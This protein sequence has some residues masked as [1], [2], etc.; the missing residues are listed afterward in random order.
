M[1]QPSGG[2]WLPVT[3]TTDTVLMMP[4]R[5]VST[6]PG[7]IQAIPPQV[8]A[9]RALLSCDVCVEPFHDDIAEMDKN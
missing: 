4:S 8:L 5:V 9:V 6:L 7:G 3:A 1:W 2:E